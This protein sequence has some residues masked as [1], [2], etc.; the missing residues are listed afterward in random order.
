MANKNRVGNFNHSARQGRVQA[1]RYFRYSPLAAALMGVVAAAGAPAWAED[2]AAAPASLQVPQ[3][4]VTATRVE[5][6]SF[7]LPVSIDVVSAEQMQ[8]A[9]LMVNASETLTRIPG[10]FAPNQYRFSSDQQVSSRGFGARSSF[11]VRGIRLYADGIPQSMPDG[12]GQLS[13]F[14]LSSAERMEILRGPFSALYGNSSG[15]VIEIFTRDG[16]GAPTVTGS[17]YGGSFDTWRADL[18]AE[19]ETGKLGYLIDSSRYDTNGYREHSAARRDQVNTKLT[20]KPDD[21]T[22]AILVAEYLDQPFNQD[23]LG[24][25]RAQM[26]VDPKQAGSTATPGINANSFNTGGS[27]SQ[28]Q[29]GLNIERRLSDQDSIQGIVWGGTRTST[30]LLAIAPSALAVSKGSGGISIIDRGFSGIDA[31]WTHRTATSVGPLTVTAGLDYEY[32]KDGR[33]GYDNNFGVQATLRRDED[34]IVWNSDQYIQAQWEVG[35]RW[36]FSGGVRQSHVA[37]ENKDHY[38]R[39][40]GVGNPDDSGSVSY[41]NTSPVLGVVFHLNPSINLYAN[42]GKGFETPTFIELAYQ[43][44]GATGL[45]FGIKPSTSRNYEAGMKAFVT[46]DTRLNIAVFQVNTDKEIVVDSTSNG[47]SVYANAG[48]TE[49]SGIEVSLDADLGHDLKG[50]LA[51]TYL[52]ATFKD[53]YRNSA[54]ATI[55]SGNVLPGA[56]KSTVYGEL[57]WKHPASGFSTGLEARYNDKV[58]VDDVNSDAAASYAILSWRGGF[59]QRQGSLKVS[60]FVRVDNLAD[61]QY[62]GGVLVNDTNGR[63]FATAPGRNYLVGVSLGMTF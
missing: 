33:T 38:I 8:N 31:R 48:K 42:A 52:D 24:L 58:Y 35:S 37:F 50:Y 2:E 27:K 1:R 62:V 5:Q 55:N 44:G 18:M 6:S 49:R 59:E 14:S 41:N 36:V 63:F 54:G 10:I 17:V 11:G 26:G 32:M 47:R 61:K 40:T 23:P 60:E 13:T 3:V 51:L 29:V 46:A 30:G 22:K 25:T 28:S 53:A 20:W 12:Q 56:P 16:K 4:V 45:N 9:Q 21:N 43:A 39:T 15:G 7:D 57:S 34:N 19:G